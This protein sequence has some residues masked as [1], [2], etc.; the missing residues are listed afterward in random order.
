M[1]KL[2]KSPAI[3]R[4]MDYLDTYRNDKYI[5]PMEYA[6]LISIIN[7]NYQKISHPLLTTSPYFDNRYNTHMTPYN[8]SYTR[9]N[10][11]NQHHYCN[12]P[13]NAIIK[14]KLHSENEYTHKLPTII[15]NTNISCLADLIKIID[16]NAYDN[17]RE[18]NIDLNALHKIRNEL[19]DME[20]MVGM[21]E[22]KKSVIDQLVY[23]IQNLHT[24][25]V[26]DFKHTVIYG[27]PGT[28]KTEIAKIIGRMYSKI[29]I[30]RNEIFKKVTRCDLVA[31]YLG[32]TAIKTKN[33]INECLG[34]CLFIDEAYSLGTGGSGDT[35]DIFSQECLDT[36]CESLSNH[37]DDLMVI[38][39]GYEDEINNTIF[40]ANRGL[41]SRFIW[42]FKTE[43]YSPKELMII[44][45]K[46][47][48]SSQWNFSLEND[49]LE[50]WFIEKH[51]KFKSFGRDMEL[52]FT[53]VKI[54]HGRR[55]YGMS[56][57]VRK[58]I[59]LIDMNEGFR[60]FTTNC[61]KSTEL[62]T[63]LYGLYL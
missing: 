59:T 30:L 7:D 8:T 44:F 29:G 40:K 24:G 49:S 6:S 21:K 32:Q 36:L 37:R 54:A 17:R 25:I 35:G 34:G 11:S 23:F 48:I 50:K 41:E 31:G 27:P 63:S 28:G 55:I 5:P 57:D 26:S 13:S 45:Q 9:D 56:I 15:I 52:L 14:N 39:A 4:F 22:L 16:N 10:E 46:K 38:I 47:V 51:K 19:V 42:R 2:E 20:N 12:I 18:Y 60:T 53:F 62:P 33:V 3:I 1:S 58:Y 61:A 43:E